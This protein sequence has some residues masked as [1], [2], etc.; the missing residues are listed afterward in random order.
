MEVC[1]EREI[2]VELHLAVRIGGAD[3]VPVDAEGRHKLSEGKILGEARI[4]RFESGCE[5][6]RRGYLVVNLG[7]RQNQGDQ[8]D[9]L[10]LKDL[11][12]SVVV[13]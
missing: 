13:G 11:H 10:P 8:I 5:A 4:R 9:E 2:A 6:F 3:N 1:D 7:R 12:F